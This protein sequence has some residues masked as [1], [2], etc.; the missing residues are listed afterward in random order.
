[1]G[2]RQFGRPGAAQTRVAA[3]QVPSQPKYD[4]VKS[5]ATVDFK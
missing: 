2:R 4:W 3:D 1:M 5:G